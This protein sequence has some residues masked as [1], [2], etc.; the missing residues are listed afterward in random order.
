MNPWTYVLVAI[1]AIAASEV[2]KRVLWP[3]KQQQEA[4]SIG[5]KLEIREATEEGIRQTVLPILNTQ[6]EILKMLSSTLTNLQISLATLAA[7]ER[8][9]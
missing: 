4:L 9:R 1:G 8:Q 6:T 5:M 2:V 3:P 7:I